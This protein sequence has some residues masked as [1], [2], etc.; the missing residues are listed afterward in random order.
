E[1]AVL[2]H[3]GK[4]DETTERHLAPL[5]AHFRSA[6]RVDEIASLG[7]QLGVTQCHR[8][9]LR[10]KRALRFAP[11]LLELLQL[12]IRALERLADRAHDVLDRLFAGRELAFCTL[13]MRAEI[14]ARELEERLR[15][16]PELL[17]GEPAEACSQLLL[18][19]RERCL[20]LGFSAV[21]CF[22]LG[23]S[24][25]ELRLEP[26]AAHVSDAEAYEKPQ[27]E[28]GAA[29]G[30]EPLERNALRQ[31]HARAISR[32]GRPLSGCRKAR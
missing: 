19:E 32:G 31:R 28:R 21:T 24:H 7:T 14:F 16:L 18:G 15:V 10:L 17:V 8:L 6:Q 1:V 9:E 25:A 22:E 23:N 5:S 2:D 26:Y 30:D 13:V 4:L 3:P 27:R 12:R 29:R 20:A 11:G